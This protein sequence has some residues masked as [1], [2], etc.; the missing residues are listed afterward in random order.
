MSGW[1][2]SGKFDGVVCFTFNLF[3]GVYGG[4]SSSHLCEKNPL[5]K[6]WS[7][8]AIKRWMASLDE[9]AGVY[10]T[11]EAVSEDLPG[12]RL[13]GESCYGCAEKRVEMLDALRP[14]YQNILHIAPGGSS[15]PIIAIICVN[16]LSAYSER[17]MACLVCHPSMTAILF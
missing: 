3:V 15:E 9:P 11:T 7:K 8:D 13:P 6:S 1:C 16:V 14:L 12:I 17:Y 10:Q 5:A 2:F 4:R